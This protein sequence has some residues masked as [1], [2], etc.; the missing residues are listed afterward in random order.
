[1]STKRWAIRDAGIAHFYNIAT[2]DLVVSLPTLKTAG[3][4]FTGKCFAH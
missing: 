3:L 1:M 2:G 4:E